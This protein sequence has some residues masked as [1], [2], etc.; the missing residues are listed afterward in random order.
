MELHNKFK[1]EVTS[2]IDNE[3]INLIEELPPIDNEA[4]QPP[5]KQHKRSPTMESRL[6]LADHDSN[7]ERS[8]NSSASS[9][10]SSKSKENIFRKLKTKL[11]EKLE[12]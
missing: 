8:I 12:K 1:K 9:R 4:A 11:K 6:S 10:K 2:P 3:K 5:L 7:K